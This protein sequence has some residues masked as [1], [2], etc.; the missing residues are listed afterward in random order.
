MGIILP[1]IKKKVS[2]RWG[3]EPASEDLEE[4]EAAYYAEQEELAHQEWS[5]RDD[6]IF[7]PDCSDPDQ[8]AY[9]FKY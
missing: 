4:I 5:R 8:P 7:R 2:E 9:P 1:F 3:Q 6:E